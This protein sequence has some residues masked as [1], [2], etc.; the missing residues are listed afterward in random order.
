MSTPELTPQLFALFARLVE[1]ACGIHYELADRE[2][3]GSKLLARAADAGFPEP[4]DYYYRL[5]YDDPDGEEL[6]LLVQSLVVHETYFFRELVPL[7]QLVDAH[8]AARIRAQ[9]RVRVWS[10]ASSTGEEPYTL[11]MLLAQRGLLDRVELVAS[12][13][14]EAVLAKARAGHHGKRSVRDGHPADL[15]ARYLEPSPTG[16]TLAP[17]IRDA[18]RFQQVN[19]LEPAAVTALGA[20]DAILCR[21]VLIYFS[22]A[23]VASVVERLAR[24]LA[25]EGLLAVGVSESLLRFGTAMICEERG[26]AFFYR[27][28]GPA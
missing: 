23:T 20:F 7:V 11:A 25:P 10:A 14:S 15:A 5:R 18:V 6:R 21:N 1:V 22:D 12:D 9:G 19:L 3:L 24:S 17:R 27:P 8:L 13:I 28:A 26:G 2:V 4:L 16:F